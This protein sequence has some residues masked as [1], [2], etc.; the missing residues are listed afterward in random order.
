MQTWKWVEKIYPMVTEE[1]D[2]KP[3][4]PV[5]MGEGAY[6]SG[7]EY[8]FDVTPL[9]VRRQAYYS[10]LAGAHHTYGHN[11]SWRVLPTW[12]QAL[13]A[14]GAMQMGILKKSIPG[15]EGVVVPGS[16]PDRVC[17]RRKHRWPSAEPRR[18]PQRWPLAHGL[19]GKQGLV[20]DPNGQDLRAA[21]K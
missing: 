3:V 10:Y 7:S 4:K 21:P 2:L 17:Q 6:E 5:V 1:Y 12:K 13:D 19:S 8:G 11:D 18:P 16:G 14:P 15:P 20:F 9:W